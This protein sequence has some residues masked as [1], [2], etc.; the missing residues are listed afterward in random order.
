MAPANEFIPPI[1]VVWCHGGSTSNS[2]Q[3]G[4]ESMA[5]VVSVHPQKSHVDGQVSV[6]GLMPSLG[7]E[8]S[9][10]VVGVAGPMAL[11]SP[12]P[13]YELVLFHFS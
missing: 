10:R 1:L 11:F 8:R 5:S 12:S 9:V 2:F 6:V 7:L 13:L 4:W 3:L